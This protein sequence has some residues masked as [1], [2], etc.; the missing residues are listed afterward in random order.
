MWLSLA[1]LLTMDVPLA[2]IKGVYFSADLQLDATTRDLGLLSLIMSV[3]VMAKKVLQVLVVGKLARHE[4]LGGMMEGE[5][6]KPAIQ[7]RAP[8]DFEGVHKLKHSDSR[9]RKLVEDS[10]GSVGVSP[11][12]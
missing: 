7:L 10:V 8:Q 11:V 4:R 12:V 6:A 2:I 9:S 3:L 5:P 1:T